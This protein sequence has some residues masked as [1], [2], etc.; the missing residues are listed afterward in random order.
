MKKLLILAALTFA[1]F[2]IVNNFGGDELKDVANNTTLPFKMAMLAAEEPE[3]QIAMPVRAV[4]V[5]SVAD[6]WHAPRSN[7]RTHQGQDIFA[8]RGTA[9]YSATEG[10]VFRIGQNALGG[11][12]VWIAG[13]GGRFYYYAHLDKFAENLKQGDYATTETIIGYVGTTGNA[14]DT[15]PHLHF[16]VYTSTGA[17]NPL[18]LLTD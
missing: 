7:E 6:T 14:K 9:V 12:N 11:N 3:A 16:G 1:G 2:F 18:P 13:A 17:I 4:K 5:K 10:Y 8:P 15:P